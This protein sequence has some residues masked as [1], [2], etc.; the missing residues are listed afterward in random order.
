MLKPILFAALLL[1]PPAFAQDAKEL[2]DVATPEQI[3]AEL[4]A[5]P[6][7]DAVEAVPTARLDPNS[8]R[9]FRLNI[10]V[11]KFTGKK[12]P[13]TLYVL[14]DGIL[15]QQ[16]AVSTGLGKYG[17]GYDTPNGVFRVDRMEHTWTSTIYDARMDRAVFFNG[18]IALHA[19]YGGNIGLL[20]TRQSHGCV[21]Q[22]PENA[23]RLFQLVKQYGAS[24]T[25]IIIQD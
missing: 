25:I 13:Q 4:Q 17:E 24:N 12:E 9:S 20:G 18:G 15:T 5:N 14:E 22:S 7:L 11:Q 2:G 1:T 3:W 23:D 10:I 21:R 8:T 6:N 16:W 19:T